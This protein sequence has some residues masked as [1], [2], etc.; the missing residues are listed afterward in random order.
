MQFNDSSVLH[1]APE[2]FT[3]LFL[4]RNRPTNSVRRDGAAGTDFD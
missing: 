3:L 2:V 4:K 1:V